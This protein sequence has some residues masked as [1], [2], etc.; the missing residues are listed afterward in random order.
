MEHQATFYMNQ[1][2]PNPVK[3]SVPMRT[4]NRD[5]RT[6][7]YLTQ[8][9]IEQ[10]TAA[11]RKG[12]NGHRDATL[13]LIGWRH[14]LR[15]GELVNVRWDQFDLNE[16]TFHV[17]R[18]KNGLPSVH[19]LSGVEI[20]ALRKLKRKQPESRYVFL[21]ERRGPLTVGGLQSIIARAG[22][23]A[24]IPF[25]VHPHMLRHT[26]GYKLANDGQDTRAIQL[27]MGH[28]NISNTTV[29]TQLSVE[30]F[31]NFFGD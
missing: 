17:N 20:R 29:Y 18:A 11:A 14:A 19:P 6:R 1:K 22:K 23:R 12:R 26:A 13:I 30:R 5:H 28:K 7:E 2:P 8:T 16:G 3:R 21:S 27:Y 25:K 15:P 9:E 24:D 10:L 31:K 4:P